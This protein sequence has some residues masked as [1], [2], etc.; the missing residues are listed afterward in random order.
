MKKYSLLVATLFLWASSAFVTMNDDI[1]AKFEK[2]ANVA[3]YQGA[4]WDNL[5]SISRG[6]TLEQ[7]YEIAYND[8]NI[9]YFFYTTGWSLV[10]DTPKGRQH[11]GHGDV[12]F[13][14]GEPWWG[15]ATDLADGYVKKNSE[16]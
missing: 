15:E 3:Q 5:V 12:A 9:N 8:P 2:V 16:Q 11:F 7:A 14:S 1:E 10:L 4:D 13:F 6:L